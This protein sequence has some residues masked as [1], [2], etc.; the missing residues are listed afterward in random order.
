MRTGLL[1]RSALLSDASKADLQ[2]IREAG[3]VLI[4]DLRT[5]SE[6]RRSPDRVPQDVAHEWVNLMDRTA[7][8][9]LA[10]SIPATRARTRGY[11]ADFVTDPTERARTA[12]VLQLILQADG[13]VLFHCTAGK[14]RT[15]WISALLQLSAGVDSEKVMRE[16]LASNDY[17]A[18][19]IEQRY[20]E[21]LAKDGQKAAEV[22]LAADRLKPEYLNAALDEVKSR[23]GDVD[24]YLRDGLG[25]S[26]KQIKQLK[27]KLTT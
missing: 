12:K 15:G 13:A 6:V 5:D 17:R 27:T 20:Q 4:I 26:A 18:D 19:L 8:P 2:R 7:V 16:Y 14:D 23:Y 3:V 10:S 1:Y 11:Y 22:R 9:G 25:L 21:T 24:T